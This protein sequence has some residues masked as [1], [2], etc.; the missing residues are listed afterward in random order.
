LRLL[1]VPE[2]D[3]PISFNSL[4]PALFVTFIV[5]ELSEVEINSIVYE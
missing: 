5:A 4:T 1:T 2:P 3:S